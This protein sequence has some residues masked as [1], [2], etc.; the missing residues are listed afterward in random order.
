M[1]RLT[2]ARDAARAVELHP[3][4][5]DEVILGEYDGEQPRQ[6]STPLRR[7]IFKSGEH[8]CEGT[9]PDNRYRQTSTLLPRA[10]RCTRVGSQ[11]MESKPAS[12]G[13]SNCTSTFSTSPS[14]M[15]PEC[16]TSVSSLNVRYGYIMVR[17]SQ[18]SHRSRGTS[19]EISIPMVANAYDISALRP[20]SPRNSPFYR[21]CPCC[22][23]GPLLA[24]RQR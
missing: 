20:V 9:A 10:S 23:S 17:S 13:L 1:N 19:L 6:L 7:H 24:P 11:R 2:I 4:S 14:S 5:F 3:A 18:L 8:C 16:V 21:F 12:V 22:S 15:M